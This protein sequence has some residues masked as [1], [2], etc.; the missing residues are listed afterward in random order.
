MNKPKSVWNDIT[1]I[2]G[3]IA[4]V[5]AAVGVAATAIVKIFNTPP[6]LTYII[7]AALGLTN[8]IYTSRDSCLWTEGK[9]RLYRNYR[10]AKNY[11]RWV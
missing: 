8:W 5:I 4:G 9:K 2:W 3:R 1:K 10:K 7:F 6:E 11:V